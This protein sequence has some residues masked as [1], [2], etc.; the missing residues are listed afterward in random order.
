[1]KIEGQGKLLRIYIGTQ[2]RLH[3]KPLY[4]MIV[5]KAYDMNL[6]GSTVIRGIEG[7][8]AASRVIHKAAIL[9]LSEHLPLLIEIVD[10]EERINAAIE[11][12]ETLIESAGKGALMTMENVEIIRYKTGQPNGKKENG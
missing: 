1:M 9:R 8:G 4:E 2:D 12:F 10:V 7:F 6:A 11:A 5:Q 3:G